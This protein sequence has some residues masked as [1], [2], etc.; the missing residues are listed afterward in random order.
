MCSSI[1]IISIL[2][3]L[4]SCLIKG[5]WFRLT[6]LTFRKVILG[7]LMLSERAVKVGSVKVHVCGE[8]VEAQSLIE[9]LQCFW[10]L[11][12]QSV[13]DGS[14]QDGGFIWWVQFKGSAVELARLC[15]R[16]KDT[17]VDFSQKIVWELI[18]VSPAQTVLCKRR[19]WQRWSVPK[20]IWDWGWWLFDSPS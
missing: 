14:V 11:P 19:E 8:R 5:V 17:W 10:N 16:R 13:S 7:W 2:M 20:R 18:W 12:Q 15:R 4:I 1:N 9:I 3:L 6:V